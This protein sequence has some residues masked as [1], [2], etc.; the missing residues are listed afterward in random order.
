MDDFQDYITLKKEI[1]N[2][3]ICGTIIFAMRL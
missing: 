1:P 3:V 2:M